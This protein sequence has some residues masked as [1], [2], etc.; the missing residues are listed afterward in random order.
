MGNTINIK[1]VMR[2][3]ADITG[4][5]S[6]DFGKLELEMRNSYVGCYMPDSNFMEQDEKVKELCLLYFR[7][8]LFEFWHRVIV[9]GD[10]TY[11]YGTPTQEGVSFKL[12]GT[13]V[14]VWEELERFILTWG[15][16]RI[17][18]PVRFLK[19]DRCEMDKIALHMMMYADLI[20]KARAIKDAKE[21]QKFFINGKKNIFK[22]EK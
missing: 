20:A 12:L 10:N 19:P 3:L 14:E 16:A 22:D 15:I 13:G 11:L 8:L 9:T 21:A 1:Q 17:G 4:C 5:E 7:Q 18:T 2:S 6:N